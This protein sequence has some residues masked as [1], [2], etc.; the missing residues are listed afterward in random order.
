MISEAWLDE[1]DMPRE[2][3]GTRGRVVK[4]SDDCCD[5]PARDD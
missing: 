2:K 5:L 4:A 1:H 3:I